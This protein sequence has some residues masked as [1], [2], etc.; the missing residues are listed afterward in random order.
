MNSFSF[1]SPNL[2]GSTSAGGSAPA[3]E[4]GLWLAKQ[5][6]IKKITQ[7]QLA[8]RSG[9]DHSTISRLM[10]GSRVPSLGTVE[11][12]ER[13]LRERYNSSGPALE[14]NPAARVEHA[15]RADSL[16]SESQVRELME[17]YLRLRQHNQIQIAAMAAV[18]GVAVPVSIVRRDA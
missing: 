14:T 8:E 10:R 16:L 17:R 13:G 12:L 3:E 7:R 15:L 11:S 18:R 9:V 6:R 4:F 1:S 5:L 2:A